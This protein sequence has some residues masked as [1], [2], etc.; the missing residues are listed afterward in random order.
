M[1]IEGQLEALIADGLERSVE[2]T[3]PCGAG[4]IISDGE[5]LVDFSS[6]DYLGM[7]I[8]PLL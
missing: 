6:N 3:V 2:N 4:K 5:E 1:T 7:S 8:E